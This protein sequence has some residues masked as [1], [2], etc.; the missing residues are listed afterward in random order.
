MPTVGSGTPTPALPSRVRWR[1][2]HTVLRGAVVVDG[3]GAP[4]RV[5]DVGI[6]GD[7]IAV[8]GSASASDVRDAEVV[9]LDGLVLAPGFIDSHTHYDAQVLW[10]PDLTPS[11][12]HGITSV[13]MGNCG[14]GIA[15]VR[16]AHHEKIMRTLENVE[17]MSYE[18]LLEGVAWG[19]ETFREYLDTVGAQPLRCNVGV[20]V[21]HTPVR[22][23]VLGSESNER[24][25]TPD[26]IAAERALVEDAL[27]ACALGFASSKTDVHVGEAGKPV[28]SRLASNEEIVELARSLGRA[29][30][31]LMQFTWGPEF[32]L[33]DLLAVAREIAPRPV[34][35]T[36]LLDQFV[37]PLQGRTPTDVLDEIDR[38]GLEVWPQVSCRPLVFQLTLEDPFPLAQGR[39]AFQEIVALP[40]RER[41]DRY[42]DVAWRDRAKR[43][44]GPEWQ[45]RWERTTVQETEAH[46]ELRN[47][48]SVAELAS[49][50]GEDP[51][52][53]I[54]DL[55]LTEDLA[56]R[57]KIVMYNY[58][59]RAVAELLRHPHTVI[60]LSDAGAH[61]SQLCDAN[62]ATFLLQHWVRELG[63]LTL[64]E[65]VYRL[66]AQ[67]ARLYGLHGRGTIAPGRFA[68]LVA[69]DPAAVGTDDVE[70]V[71][72]LPA[73]ADR[74]IARS[75]G[76]EATWVNGVQT[77]ENGSVVPGAAPGRIIRGARS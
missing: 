6:D 63:V 25:A 16:P 15:P 65:A 56:T 1:T 40:R 13:V 26:E 30:H 20:F 17:A 7:R 9:D 21:G 33:D 42:R 49:A 18:A 61:A 59:E 69:F 27:D 34:T 23:Y 66:T 2:V 47:G 51:F 10:D 50:R 60:N 74:L 8:V 43:E 44:L 55:A 53:I 28:P 22:L 4:G 37:Q 71:W 52:D 36:A 14:F 19:F 58:D 54:A 68:D 75:R 46:G 32:G 64:E 12:W 39:P 29:D 31:G 73:G 5:A 70:R 11:S 48:P 67:P 76:I 62:F 57:F 45:A 24:A 3:T 38:S 72:D 77:W 35:F 41:A